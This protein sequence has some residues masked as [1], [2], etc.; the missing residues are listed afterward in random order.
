MKRLIGLALGLIVLMPALIL[1]DGE[2]TRKITQKYPDEKTKEITFYQDGKEIARE[3]FDEKGNRTT[4]KGK[5]PDG[6]VKGYYEN[7][8]LQTEVNYKDDKREGIGKRYYE[9]GELQA[10]TNY[11]DG[12]QE[13]IGKWYYKSGKL[14][15]EENYKDGKQEVIGKEYHKSGK[16]FS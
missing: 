5:I 10:E 16:L 8:K 15:S 14:D 2:V 4:I 12:K 1:A 7:E 11:K 9:S 13:G 6:V 3:L